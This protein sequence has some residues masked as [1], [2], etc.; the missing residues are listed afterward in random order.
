MLRTA[1]FATFEAV[2]PEFHVGPVI[3]T[4]YDLSARVISALRYVVSRCV[5]PCY[6]PHFS[7]TVPV[8][9]KQVCWLFVAC[10]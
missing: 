7:R 2:N 5:V 10:A 9:H 8:L 6:L 4:W 3:A 1:F